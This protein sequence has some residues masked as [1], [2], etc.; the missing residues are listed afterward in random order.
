MTRD[1]TTSDARSPAVQARETCQMCQGTGLTA[2]VL[3][4]LT[5]DEITCPNCNGGKGLVE[6]E[7]TKEVV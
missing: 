1:P 3:P 2:F 7:P 4:N 5:R 6:A